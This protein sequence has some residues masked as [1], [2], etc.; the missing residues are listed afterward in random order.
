[1]Q[2][3]PHALVLI[4]EQLLTGHDSHY[5]GGI[6]LF[7]QLCRQLSGC[8][9]F[10]VVHT[11]S[12]ATKTLVLHHA[13]T[14]ELLHQLQTQT[15]SCGTEVISW[16]QDD[17]IHHHVI[18]RQPSAAADPAASGLNSLGGSSTARAAAA[19][20]LSALGDILQELAAQGR[21][22]SVILDTDTL[23]HASVPVLWPPGS[24]PTVH[25]AAAA[26]GSC[27]SNSH[28]QAI[29]PLPE[30]THH[31]G[32]STPQQA[33]RQLQ[34]DVEQERGTDVPFML[35]LSLQLQACL[36]AQLTEQPQQLITHPHTP[37]QLQSAQ[38]PSN[39]SVRQLRP[40]WTLLALVQNIHH[41]PFGPC[42][43][44]PRSA[45][46]LQGWR[47]VAGVICVSEFVRSYLS[48]HAVPLLPQLQPSHL[49]VTHPAA[50][51][52]W[53]PG[54]FVDLGTAAAARLWG[55]VER[56]AA[57]AAE[58]C[59]SRASCNEGTG[60]AP[61]G[62]GQGDSFSDVISDAR[63]AEPGSKSAGGN[64]NPAAGSLPQ[65]QP[66]W[67]QPPVVG[68]LKMTRE[69]GSALF[70]AL[71]RQL[72][73]L[74]F[75]AVCADPSVQQEVSHSA[76]LGNVQLLDPAGEWGARNLFC[77]GFQQNIKREIVTGLT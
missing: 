5:A 76:G 3:P 43:T 2:Q 10:D 12:T 25:H 56:P 58:R 30:S 33:P 1:M 75:L 36:Q 46:V 37:V 45:G 42:G 57:H 60:A 61:A 69:K 70:L 66:Q 19:A 20:V 52:V 67:Q 21:A 68:M 11:L 64:L 23:Q 73:A 47:A 72:P 62:V 74:Q 44:A 40:T 18:V 53:G 27:S 29:N 51:G 24:L 48:Q 14:N 17:R 38:E 65:Q 59:L 16:K 50:F 41:L 9:A 54:P 13:I 4:K 35:A 32:C 26:D 22:G 34:Q 49:H 71:A 77:P 7:S 15:T 8:S 63:K 39:G 6:H 28:T 31:A 55:G